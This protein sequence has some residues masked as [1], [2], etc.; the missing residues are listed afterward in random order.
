MPIQLRDLYIN[1]SG[2]DS[3]VLFLLKGCSYEHLPMFYLKKISAKFVNPILT[4]SLTSSATGCGDHKWQL[5]SQEY[6]ENLIIAS[7]T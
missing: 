5:L 6:E 1:V 7:A 3:S 2:P 4:V